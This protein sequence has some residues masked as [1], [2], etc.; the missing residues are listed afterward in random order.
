[1]TLTTARGGWLWLAV[2]IVLVGT[3]VIIAALTRLAPRYR[4]PLLSVI[5]FAS[6]LFYAL[7]FFLPTRAITNPNG[8]VTQENFIGS[9]S[10]TKLIPEV[11]SP[12]SQILGALVLGLG[13]FSLARIHSNNVAR[14]HPGW[15]NSLA[16]LLAAAAMLTIGLWS[17]AN[18][19]SHPGIDRAFS[20]LFDGLQQNMDAA[21][22]SLISFF[23]LS[24]AY[25]AFRIRSL[26]ASILMGAALIVLLGLSFGVILTGWVPDRGLTANLRVETWSSWLL[27]VVSS[28]ALR[29]IDF[30]IGIGGLAMGLRIWLGIERGAL[31]GD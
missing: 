25:R 23:I 6:G 27:T 8:T 30:G 13:L 15:I 26:E 2:A 9:V 5:V 14:A 17:K 28:P 21:M 29:A 16:L 4:R 20:Y 11:I 3:V 1:M 12:F 24:A 10:L 19:G 7:E 31:F 18:T 22:F